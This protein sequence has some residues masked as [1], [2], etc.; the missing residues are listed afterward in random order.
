MPDPRA[1]RGGWGDRLRTLFDYT[2]VLFSVV[3]GV[4]CARLAVASWSIAGEDAGG[5]LMWYGLAALLAAAVLVFAWEAVHR[6]RRVRARRRAVAAAGGT[7]DGG[8]GGGRHP[9]GGGKR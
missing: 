3:G 1:G 2:I 5:G 8:G 4:L 6:L 9:G 7:G